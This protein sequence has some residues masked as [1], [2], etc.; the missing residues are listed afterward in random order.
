MDLSVDPCE[1]FYEFSCGL[2]RK[3]TVIPE[4]SSFYGTLSEVYDD[5]QVTNKCEHDFTDYFLLISFS[6]FKDASCSNLIF[7]NKT[8]N[9]FTVSFEM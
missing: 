1:D 2:W 9:Y 3:K 5:I 7:E 4:A 6:F 8:D